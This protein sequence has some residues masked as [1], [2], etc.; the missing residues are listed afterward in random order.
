MATRYKKLPSYIATVSLER[1]LVTFFLLSHVTR[2]VR[3]EGREQTCPTVTLH[4]L[5]LATMDRGTPTGE[6]GSFVFEA[7]GC[8]QDNWRAQEWMDG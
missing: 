8:I 7:N 1:S 5:D 6:L 3:A 4:P 2:D